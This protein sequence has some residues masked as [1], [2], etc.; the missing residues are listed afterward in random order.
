VSRRS[1]D[2]NQ[3]I[4]SYMFL[5]QTVGWIGTLLPI[6][7]LVGNAISS[8]TPRPYS[9]SGY[10]YTDMRNIF[11]GALWALGVFLVAYAG[12]DDVD[13]WITNIAGLGA[14]GVALC[15]TKPTVCTAGVGVC[16]ASSVTHL[17][18]SQQVVGDIHVVFAA[19]TLIALGLMALRFA[20]GGMTPPRQSTMGQLRYG[21]GFGKPGDGSQP[22]QY[23][24]DNVIY[25]ISGITILSC[26]LLAALSNL[27][28]ASVKAQWPW[29][30]IFEAVAV[31]AFGVSWFVKGRTIQG[32]RARIRK[33]RHATAAS[34]PD[35]GTERSPELN[36]GRSATENQTEPS[37]SA[38]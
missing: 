15:P 31:F 38:S 8:T 36:L 28:P 11:V 30:F 2:G 12:Y 13:R 4:V 6:V 16:P 1:R 29:L 24:G 9:I 20:K 17:S 19:V 7:L 25:R 14:I 35:P 21:L 37:P 26:V 23:T 22:Q 33:A 10:Y 18:T 34:T 27:L 5:R 3:L 32:I